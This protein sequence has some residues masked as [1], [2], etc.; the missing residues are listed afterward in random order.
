MTD[1]RSLPTVSVEVIQSAQMPSGAY[2]ASPSFPTY[3]YSWFRD[4]AFTAYAMQLAGQRDSARRF[5]E[6]AI[7]T[8][9]HEAGAAKSTITRSKAGLPISGGPVLRAR[10]SPDG[11][12]PDQGWPNFQLDGLGTWL[13]SLQAFMAA[14]PKPLRDALEAVDLVA[15][16]LA[17][18]WRTPCFDC[19]EENGDQIHISTLAAI[20]GGLTAAA[21]LLGTPQWSE[22]AAAVREFVLQNG[23]I[24][25]RLRKHLGTDLVDASLLWVSTPFRLLEPADPLMR[26]T[27]GDVV[28]KLTGPGGGVRRYVGDSFYGGGQWVLLTA[29][30]GWYL[31][32]VGERKR[33]REYLAWVEHAA[34]RQGL[35]PEQVV[36]HVQQPDKLTEWAARWGPVAKP[37]LWSHA[38]YLILHHA[39]S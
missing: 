16:Y 37:L 18:L 33:S 24:D 7:A 2:L 27:T 10:Y 22:D 36:D 35:L 23:T 15:R 34:D 12:Q 13:W 30:L 21:A 26:I 25:G 9:G 31:S 3:R 38:T 17:Q 29:H 1:T 8:I 39:L 20:Y 32:E 14:E 11:A 5:H 28:Q 6:W 4:G 19:W